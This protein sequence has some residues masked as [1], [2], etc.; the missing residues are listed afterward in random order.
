M[1]FFSNLLSIILNCKKKK[2]RRLASARLNDQVSVAENL[3]TGDGKKSWKEVAGNF[4]I[5]ES[6][7]E[8]EAQWRCHVEKGNLTCAAAVLRFIPW[9]SGFGT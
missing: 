9:P 4:D 8:L 6:T 7:P 3:L 2:I 1:R 5:A